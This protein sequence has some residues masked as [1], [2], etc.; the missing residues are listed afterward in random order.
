MPFPT[1]LTPFPVKCYLKIPFPPPNDMLI[2]LQVVDSQDICPLFSCIKWCNTRLPSHVSVIFPSIITIS[3]LSE[4]LVAPT[5]SQQ[6]I[7]VVINTLN[8][9]FVLFGSRT[10]LQSIHAANGPYADFSCHPKVLFP[11]IN[12]VSLLFPSPS[13]PDNVL[14]LY[15]NIFLTG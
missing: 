15:G 3:H 4:R 11:S 1:C 13:L 10:S 12:A 14:K 7:A 8:R 2:V 5:V 6:S 9:T